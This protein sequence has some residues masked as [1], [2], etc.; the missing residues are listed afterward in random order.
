MNVFQDFEWPSWVDVFTIISHLALTIS[1]SL[2]FYIYYGKYGKPNQ[3][4]HHY[5]R[6]LRNF[7]KTPIRR[8]NFSASEQLNEKYAASDEKSMPDIHTAE[9]VESTI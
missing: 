2:S 8:N 4:I 3:F 6:K 9:I 1:S 7:F 5:A